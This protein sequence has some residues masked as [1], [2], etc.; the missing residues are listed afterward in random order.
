[1]SIHTPSV[2]S[3]LAN[4]AE[5]WPERP[6][7]VDQYGRL[8]Y[9]SLLKA[10]EDMAALLAV[11]GIRKGD[12]VGVQAVNGR[13]FI[14]AV[15]AAIRCGATV[16]PMYH[17][18]WTGERDALLKQMPLHFIMTDHRCCRHY[19]P[20]SRIASLSDTLQL[21]LFKTDTPGS[22][23]VSDVVPDA[24][25]VRFT[26]G[27][28][29]RAKGV[30]LTHRNILER[31]E[32]TNKGLGL[33]EKDSVLS[34]LPMAFHFYV[35]II[36]YLYV[37]ASIFIPAEQSASALMETITT[38]RITFLYA[39]PY[40]YRMLLA[41]RPERDAFRSLRRVVSTSTGLPSKIA[42]EFR[43][44]SGLGISQAYGI[45]EIGLP[46]MNLDDNAS[47]PEAIGRT[48]P[49][50][51]VA[52]L[53]ENGV[54]Q[55]LGVSGH[56]AIKGPGMFSA[57]LAPF[58]AKADVLKN[59]WFMTGDIASQGPDG[60]LT[61]LGREKS[62]INV[63]GEKVFPEEVEEILNAHPGVAETFVY[64]VPHPRMGEV[65]HARVIPRDKITLTPE[66]LI[67]YAGKWLSSFKVPQHISFA[68]IIEMTSSGKAFRN[69]QV[70]LSPYHEE[71]CTHVV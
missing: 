18:L 67:S 43:R 31:I 39:S 56:L 19:H 53:D 13:G 33:T 20:S 26:S 57:Y 49:D 55:E 17:E 41:A 60:I 16:M 1:M 46:V 70:Y 30:V 69:K 54:R 32:A 29:G 2:F 47:T 45:I 21:F 62:M 63:C 24:A 22:R 34:L 58:M 71:N 40:H 6:A 10:T 50:Y 42:Y 65:V 52:I 51:E 8:D 3:V 15:F 44:M 37:G 38:N 64:G 14:I 25:F 68:D 28:T 48:L 12:G 5:R 35:S 66:E 23:R 36:L 61:I 27:T 9:S 11:N 7:I 59:G 4:S